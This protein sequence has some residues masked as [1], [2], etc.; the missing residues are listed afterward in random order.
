M[1]TISNSTQ[2]NITTSGNAIPPSNV[3]VSQVQWQG[4]TTIGLIVIMLIALV[5]E[6]APPYLVMMGILIIFVPL[7][8]LTIEEAFYG[9]ADEAMLSV[10]VLFIV[11]K[12]F[13]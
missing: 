2:F 11:A 3:D 8:I 7:G 13:W 12:G 9:F 4:W 10:A 5:A 1:S 6:M